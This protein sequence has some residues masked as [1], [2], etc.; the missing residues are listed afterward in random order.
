MTKVLGGPIQL[1]NDNRKVIV[2]LCMQVTLS[3][4]ANN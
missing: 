2:Y 4:R 1:K 3:C